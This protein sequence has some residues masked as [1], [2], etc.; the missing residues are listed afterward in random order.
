MRDTP[1]LTQEDAEA[2]LHFLANTDEQFGKLQTQVK[3]TLFLADQARYGI[4][5][6]SDGKNIEE[7]KAKSIIDEIY[8]NKMRDH[9]K[10]DKDMRVL[11]A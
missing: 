10:A 2:A 7:R 4:F 3:A 6:D 5:L 9:Y 11:L 1:E 8:A